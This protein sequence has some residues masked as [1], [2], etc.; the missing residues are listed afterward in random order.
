MNKQLSYLLAIC[1]LSGAALSTPLRAQTAEPKTPATQEAKDKKPAAI[2]FT[3][4]LGAVDKAA[5]SITLDGKTKKRTI[6]LTPQTRILRAGKPATLD[7]AVVGEE[8]G[9]QAIKNAE[10]QEEAVSLRVGPKPETEPKPKKQKKDG[11][12]TKQ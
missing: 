4:K 11:Q 8:V 12:A 2:P 6:R 10:G 9:G 1:F 7:D 5:M 3:G